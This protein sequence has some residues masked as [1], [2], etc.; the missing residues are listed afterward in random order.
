MSGFIFTIICLSPF[1]IFV[2][3]FVYI[4][5]HEMFYHDIEIRELDKDSFINEVKK[6]QESGY[7]PISDYIIEG[8]F[9][10]M[11]MRKKLRKPDDFIKKAQGERI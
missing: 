3:I 11:S 8:S 2:S 7:Y 9:Y 6:Y 4:G 10:K 1:I 5:I